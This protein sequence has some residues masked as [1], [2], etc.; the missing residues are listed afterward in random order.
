MVSYHSESRKDEKIFCVGDKLEA[1]TGSKSPDLG[2]REEKIIG[3]KG[4]KEEKKFS[5]KKKSTE[6]NFLKHRGKDN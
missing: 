2:K 5:E 1:R 6:K 3:K 4:K